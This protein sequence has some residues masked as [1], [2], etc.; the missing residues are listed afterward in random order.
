MAM[1][2][3]ERF[4]LHANINQKV[5]MD[6]TGNTLPSS[7]LLSVTQIAT[8]MKPSTVFLKTQC[9]AELSTGFF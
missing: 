5:M 6:A 8:A 4:H 3:S 1:R 7:G 9:K 2:I